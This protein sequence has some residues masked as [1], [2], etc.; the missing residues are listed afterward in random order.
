M[1]V[2]FSLFQLLPPFPFL[3]LTLRSM[4]ALLFPGYPF[5]RRIT[6]VAFC[7][8]PSL[9]FFPPQA[10]DKDWRRAGG[11]LG[12]HFPT[13]F[14]FIPCAKSDRTES[15]TRARVLPFLL[16]PSPL[17]PFLLMKRHFLFWCFQFLRTVKEMIA[18]AVSTLLSFLF[19]FFLLSLPLFYED[20][21]EAACEPGF[22]HPLP[23]LPF[24]GSSSALVA[25]MGVTEVDLRKASSFLSSLPPLPL[26]PFYHR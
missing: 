14:S 13:P 23:V 4:P 6:Y 15:K 10:L 9:S 7:F 18:T 3:P 19:F 1:L 2:L 8:P 24:W 21:K 22:R 26:F 12:E 17:F 25:M 16:F 20:E 11:A 5:G